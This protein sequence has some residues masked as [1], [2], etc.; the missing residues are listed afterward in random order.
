MAESSHGTIDGL[1]LAGGRSTRFGS[2]KASALLQG[3]PLLQWVI[4]ALDPVCDRIVLVCARGQSLPP[5]V[6]RAELVVAEDRYE[7]KGPLAGLVTGFPLVTAPLCF[8]TSC[9]APLLRTELVSLLETL[10][11]GYDVV[12]PD[13]GGFQQP[14]AAVYRAAACLPVFEECVRTDRLR[15]V[16]AFDDL[17]TLMVSEDEVRHADP[18]LDSFRNA[19]RPERLTEIAELLAARGLAEGHH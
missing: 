5:V 12:C 11:E 10:A 15:I 1:V 7:A 6:S 8:A 4:S 3:M 2:D 19:N 18:E 14:L 9:D 16:P 13:V 17:R